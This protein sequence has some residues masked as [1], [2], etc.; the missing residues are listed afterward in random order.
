MQSGALPADTK[1][2]MVPI[3]CTVL[4]VLI[5]AGPAAAQGTSLG[6]TTLGD[7]AKKAD[8]GRRSAPP[9]SFT[10]RDLVGV[11]WIITQEGLEE[12]AEARVEI[13]ALR[14]KN[15]TL[16][17]RLFDASRSARVLSD[18]STPLSADA[19]VVQVFSRHRLTSREYLR[20][21]QALL[22]ATAWAALKP[23]PGSIRSRPIR[24]QNVEFVR[25]NDKLLRDMTARY[26]KAEGS[27]PWFSPSRF[28]QQP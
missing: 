17:Q 15:A 8:E 12:Y 21:E 18:L 2:D 20:R 11:E 5:A 10:E 26:Q 3:R 28:V 13:A 16:N 24:M 19:T 4:L 14:R 1:L 27:P 9:I 23:L 22:N 6:G 7:A 25:T